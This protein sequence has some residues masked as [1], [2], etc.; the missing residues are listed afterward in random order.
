MALAC[1]AGAYAFGSVLALLPVVIGVVVLVWTAAMAHVGVLITHYNVRV[2]H[3]LLPMPVTS[4]PMRSIRE[5]RAI[6][7]APTVSGRWGLTWMPGRH[8]S[9]IVRSGPAL[10]VEL[11]TG[12]RFV[13]SVNEPEHAVTVFRQFRTPARA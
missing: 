12:E 11:G 8:R 3:G 9:M 7:V 2:R 1:F 5:L 4:L 10:H 6:D 13:V